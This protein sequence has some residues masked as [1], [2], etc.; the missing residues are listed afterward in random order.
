MRS[1]ANESASVPLVMF[2]STPTV[3]SFVKLR[4]NGVLG[5]TTKTATLVMP[6][7]H[8]SAPNVFM[9]LRMTGSIQVVDEITLA[10]PNTHAAIN[11]TQPL[12]LFHDGAAPNATM[13]LFLEGV[14]KETGFITMALPNAVG[15]VN[16]QLDFYIRGY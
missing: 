1:S 10:M 8:T 2:N 14:F 13:Q 6:N 15:P 16:N 12:I 4:I 7:V 9:K 3:N 5:S 11:A